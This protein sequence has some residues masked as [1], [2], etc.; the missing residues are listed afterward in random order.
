MLILI[1][2]FVVVVN[3]N[4]VGMMRASKNVK[5]NMAGINADIESSISGMR[6]AKA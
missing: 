5:A 3:L 2:V 1:P 4:R 6:T